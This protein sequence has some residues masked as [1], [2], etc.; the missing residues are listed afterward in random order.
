MLK[1]L[2]AIEGAGAAGGGRSAMLMAQVTL[3]SQL[4][5]AARALEIAKRELASAIQNQGRQED[6]VA[7]VRR[8][9]ADMQWMN[10]DAA[11]NP[12]LLQMAVAQAMA[13]LHGSI[14]D[15]QKDKSRAL[16]EIGALQTR[17]V[18]QYWRVSA[19]EERR[20][21]A[22]ADESTA[23]QSATQAAD[24]KTTDARAAATAAAPA[25]KDA[26]PPPKD[27]ALNDLTDLLIL[28]ALAVAEAKIQRA[29]PQSR[30]ADGVSRQ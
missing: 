12:N 17:V 26:P 23:S 21:A 1:P 24:R 16:A 22:R 2:P 30:R 5:Q 3:D 8:R 10:G 9:L 29:E 4:D 25:D 18:Q 6:V 13:T 19:L 27:A 20:R 7:A 14:E 28:R 11:A 15:A